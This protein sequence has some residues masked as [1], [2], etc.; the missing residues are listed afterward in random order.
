MG[1]K[2]KVIWLYKLYA[3]EVLLAWEFTV[4]H[5]IYLKMSMAACN[6]WK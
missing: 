1:F 2:N 5:N 3:N 6:T 4:E